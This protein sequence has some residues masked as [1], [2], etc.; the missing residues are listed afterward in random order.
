MLQTTA[1]LEAARDERIAAKMAAGENPADAGDLKRK[2]KKKKKKDK[3]V[4]SF[5]ADDEDDDG[6]VGPVFPSGEVYCRGESSRDI[7]PALDTVIFIRR[8]EDSSSKR[9][10]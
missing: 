5:N 4:L 7:G 10:T 9:L 2:K 3:V 8:V 1:D 6:E